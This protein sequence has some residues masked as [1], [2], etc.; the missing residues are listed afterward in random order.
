MELEIIPNAMITLVAVFNQS[1]RRALSAELSLTMAE[2][3]ILSSI[4]DEGLSSVSALSK[5]LDILP[6]RV[7]SSVTELAKRGYLD[8]LPS[9][10]SE[11]RLKPTVQGRFCNDR[12]RAVAADANE[13]VLSSVP[14][15]LRDSFAVCFIVAAVIEEERI[16]RNGVPDTTAMYVRVFS[17][18]ERLITKTAKGHGMS[19]MDCRV[20][21][22][23]LDGRNELTPS[24]LCRMLVAP[25]SSVSE[26]L[27]RLGRAG[28]VALEPLDGRSV[29]ASLC[30]E[31]VCGV[32]RLAHELSEAIHKAYRP[33]RKEERVLCEQVADIVAENARAGRASK[34]GRDCGSSSA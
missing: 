32:D 25:K 14:R 30:E 34:R 20:A 33:I 7:S 19:F 16:Y 12:A 22:A 8:K 31:A 5:R 15:S 3:L 27:G 28:V 11:G 29:A 1:L 2:Y 10:S 13:A 6:P 26:S 24:Q 4:C 9:G 17:R 18:T 23:L 21:L